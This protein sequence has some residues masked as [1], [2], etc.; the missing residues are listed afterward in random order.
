MKSPF[1]NIESRRG[2]TNT[3]E[4]SQ[5]LTER[6]PAPLQERAP[7]SLARE[8][9]GGRFEIVHASA[10]T[11]DWLT[12]GDGIDL[13]EGEERGLWKFLFYAGSVICVGLGILALGG[14]LLAIG[15]FWTTAG[16]LG[17]I[18]SAL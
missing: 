7:Q 15:G 17:F 16:V 11:T 5:R 9:V 3:A 14:T 1:N 2:T 4:V 12:D 18:G 10:G 13:T 8:Q 6:E